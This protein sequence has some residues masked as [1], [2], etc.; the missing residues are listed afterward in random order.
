MNKRVDQT[1]KFV[2]ED[3]WDIELTSL[4]KL[5]RWGVQS[6]RVVNL[7]VRGFRED[8]CPL[9]ASALTFNTLMAIVPILALSLSLARV[10]GGAELA[11]TQLREVVGEL[12]QRLEIS[13]PGSV[14][15]EAPVDGDVAAV[16]KVLNKDD[17]VWTPDEIALELNN[18][19][20]AG[21]RQVKQINFAALG[22]LG[23]VLLL[24]MVIAVLGRVE[25]SFNTV[26]GVAQGR[27]M[28]RKITDY[29]F[30][31]I[32]LPFLI[33]MA[34]SFSI[35]EMAAHFLQDPWASYVR[36]FIDSG[37]FK[38]L[39]TMLLTTFTFTVLIKFMPNT[40]VR[41]N[42][43]IVGGLVS[44]LMFIFWLWFCARLQVGV[45]KYSKLYGSFAVVPIVLFWVFV[46]WEI[47]LFGA[48]VAF[49]V[50][51]CT[52]YRMEFGSRMANM[53]SRIILSLSVIVEAG[54][55]MLGKAGH[56]ESAE[57][58]RVHRVP[59]RFLNDIVQEMVNLGYLASITDKEDCYVLL[60]S[61]AEI[62][63]RS[64]VDAMMDS[65]IR[66]E[67]LG[68]INV[69]PRI[70]QVIKASS[71]GIGGSLSDMTLRDLIENS[72]S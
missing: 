11:E 6:L 72:S 49:S 14:N 12:T 16:K 4:T 17:G 35:A 1:W 71:M 23:L 43:A 54:R 22:S 42:P 40:R 13:A 8:E 38:G 10:F 9:H 45:A 51:N 39:T 34:A 62:T 25:S 47:V 5:K 29:L 41:W 66:P 31:V 15:S 30:M 50:Q 55:A 27:P 58:A 61:P 32:I 46:S 67:A 63:V 36:S 7:V 68:L 64:I 69:D 28:F 24:W 2:S 21:F 57:Y 26:W 3:I 37:L 59:V 65:G 56:F 19:L 60:R 33:T 52:T 20:D 53:Q 18:A 44:A 70:E 48:E